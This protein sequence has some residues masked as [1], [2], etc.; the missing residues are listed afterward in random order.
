MAGDLRMRRALVLAIAAGGVFA[1]AFVAGFFLPHHRLAGLGTALD[2]GRALSAVAPV[3]AASAI[4]AL[5]AETA[6]A[7]RGRDA[8]FRWTTA[9][10]GPALAAHG[11]LLGLQTSF[12]GV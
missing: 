11:V 1:A 2:L 3:L 7:W 10:A 6:M 5:L 4:L 12:S 9:A 8:G